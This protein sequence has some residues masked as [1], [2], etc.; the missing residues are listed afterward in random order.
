MQRVFRNETEFINGLY[1]NFSVHFFIICV[2]VVHKTE[3]LT[4]ILRCLTGQTLDWIKRYGLRCN[5]RPWL[6]SA[7]SKEIVADK[8]PFLGHI[9]PFFLPI[10]RSYFTKLRFRWSFLGANQVYILVGTK[11]MTKNTKV[12]KTG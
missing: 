6:S 4:V 1:M 7:N 10:T 5:L 11:V 9:W 3:V 2:F 12:Q 8:K